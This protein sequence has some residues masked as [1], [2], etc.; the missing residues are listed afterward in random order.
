M[1]AEK[2]TPSVD[3][4][5]VRLTLA[6]DAWNT[7]ESSGR[8]GWTQYR[9]INANMPHKNGA[10]NWLYGLRRS[11]EEV[12]VAASSRPGPTPVDLAEKCFHAASVTRPQRLFERQ[13]Q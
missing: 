3:A 2:A 5:I 9:S 8:S 1:A 7:R 11:S 10:N 4:L 6:S 12:T 13:S